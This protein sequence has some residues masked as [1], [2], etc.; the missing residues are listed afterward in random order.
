MGVVDHSIEMVYNSIMNS[1]DTEYVVKVVFIEL[2]NEEIKD[3][4]AVE[5]NENLKI[6]EDPI[7]GPSI[8]NIREESFVDIAETRRILDEGDRRRHFGVT[9]MNAHSSRSHVLVR[10]NIEARKVY[11]GQLSKPL[12]QS[13][14][15]DKPT[16]FSTLNLVDLAGSE[17]A[18]KAGT[19]G[20][21][22]KEGSY[23]NKSLLTLGTVIAHLSDDSKSQA[24]IPYRNSKLT[25][26]LA[27]ALG[28]NARTSMV[29]CISPARGNAH[30]SLSTLRFASRA[31]KV[32]N[33]VRKNL[34]DDA[35]SLAELLAKQKTEME[36]LREEL[37]RSKLHGFSEGPMKEKAIDATRRLRSLKFIV[38]NSN[39]LVKALGKEGKH[40]IANNVRNSVRSAVQGSREI[41][42]VLDEHRDVM[43][44]HFA[45][46]STMMAAVAV[47]DHLN[48]L[49]VLSL[50]RE[51]DDG[52]SVNSFQYPS[53]DDLGDIVGDLVDE[54]NAIYIERIKMTCEEYRT[55]A[56]NRINALLDE[57]KEQAKKIV[58]YKRENGELTAELRTTSA[59][60][61]ALSFAEGALKQTVEEIKRQM[62]EAR[63]DHIEKISGM[64][65]Q[66]NE[67]E[68]ATETGEKS[69]L[70]FQQALSAKD[71]EL[72]RLQTSCDQLSKEIEKRDQEMQ[73]VQSE[74]AKSRAQQRTQVE[75]LRSNMHSLRQQ[76]GETTKVLELQNSFL[77]RDCELLRDEL[78]AVRSS[79]SQLMHEVTLLRAD[80]QRYV[81][82]FQQMSEELSYS[83]S[84]V[85]FCGVSLLFD[86][87]NITTLLQAATAS[88]QVVGLKTRMARLTTR[89]SLLE[90]EN[91]NVKRQLSEA[92]KELVN[93]TE[94]RSTEVKAIKTSSSTTIA[95]LR[96]SLAVATN[97]L[98]CSQELLL[99]K[100]ADLQRYV[101]MLKSDDN[102]LESKMRAE[103]SWHFAR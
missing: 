84:E 64:Q 51:D 32:V 53:I 69:I 88:Q 13:W 16:C 19:S 43:L 27:T 81:S 33:V 40:A 92:N 58:E 29:A 5:H 7:L 86:L 46:N 30:E 47:I 54:E 80:V 15:K 37:E 21:S 8:L 91:T 39:Q 96:N 12:R 45:D 25:R 57:N 95:E 2:Y 17:R 75:Q 87:C 89:C 49:D 77:H 93:A 14:G 78:E 103:V 36:V 31:K 56:S 102:R 82:E 42:E 72:S 23:I 100:D 59:E 62:E 34:F 38:M 24:H 6:I 41:S 3:L 52:N 98:Q 26:L 65:Q 68:S 74:S 94:V 22:L 79:K 73:N 67:L 44:N 63:V 85:R 70:T 20:Q 76:G 35:R 18:N 101:L 83:K 61:E 11:G 66:I 99:S 50:D 48:D 28:G 60:V 90:E 55:I 10:L 9:N 71:H 97:E 1:V 4:L